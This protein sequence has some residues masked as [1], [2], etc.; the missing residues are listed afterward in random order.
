MADQIQL[1][2]SV[3]GTDPADFA[4]I[5]TILDTTPAACT[6]PDPGPFQPGRTYIYEARRLDPSG[7]VSAYSAPVF[8]TAP[9][10]IGADTMAQT[11]T[12]VQTKIGMGREVTYGSPVLCQKLIDRKSGTPEIE[13]MNP[14]H[15]SLRNI[16]TDVEEV[17]GIAKTNGQVK[18]TVT[19]EGLSRPLCSLLG[20]PT[21]VATAAAA[22]PPAVG[23]FNTHT[24]IDSFAQTPQTIQEVKGPMFLVYPGAKAEGLTVTVD[25]TQNT[26]V[27]FDFTFNALNKLVIDTEAHIGTDVAGFDPLPAFGPAQVQAIINNLVTDNARKFSLALKKATSARDVLNQ[28]LGP[29]AHFITKTDLTG[30]IDQY[31]DSDASMKI[32]FGNLDASSTPYGASKRIRTIPLQFI[33]LSEVNAANFRNAIILTATKCSYKKVGQAVQGPQEI[34]QNIAWKAYH[35]PAVGSCFTLQIVNSETL[36]TITAP[37]TGLAAGTVPANGVQALIV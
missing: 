32:H 6:W 19:P 21:T 22:G 17:P 29:V 26:P 27:E 15:E 23:A 18:V 31:F 25:K 1:F 12:G 11:A 35:D 4:L 5:Q 24:Y 8:V 33:F 14:E 9:Y 20:D 2:R 16:T 34:M 13:F 10:P 36:A 7:A 30:D 28:Y 3:T 37:G